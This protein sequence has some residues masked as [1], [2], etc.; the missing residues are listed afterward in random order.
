MIS[1][2]NILFEYVFYIAHFNF[3]GKQPV[4]FEVIF[5]TRIQENVYA[6]PEEIFKDEVF[7]KLVHTKTFSRLRS[8][9]PECLSEAE[10]K[11]IATQI[12]EYCK[13]PENPKE[14]ELKDYS[15]VFLKRTIEV[16]N[17]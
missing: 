11:Q 15:R 5:M 8:L 3:A 17:Y 4:E 10:K 1:Y 2:H 16:F 9:G 12:A 14:E 7:R 13:L 6:I